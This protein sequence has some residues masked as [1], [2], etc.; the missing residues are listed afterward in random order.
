MG[1]SCALMVDAVI[2]LASSVAHDS[3]NVG[4][5]HIYSPFSL[6]IIVQSSHVRRHDRCFLRFSFREPHVV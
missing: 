1:T 4:S 2:A 5:P 6:Q 3:E